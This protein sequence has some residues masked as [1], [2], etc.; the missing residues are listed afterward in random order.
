MQN[1]AIELDLH[2]DDFSNH[3]DYQIGFDGPE[4][5]IGPDNPPGPYLRTWLDEINYGQR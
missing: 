3:L 2:D 4:H 5:A 1:R